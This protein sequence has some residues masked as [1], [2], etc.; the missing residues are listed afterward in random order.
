MEPTASVASWHWAQRW[1]LRN[2]FIRCKYQ[3]PC[4]R[5]W[6]VSEEEG[7]KVTASLEFIEFRKAGK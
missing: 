1:S 6:E 4:A 5:T 3:L 2:K 7:G